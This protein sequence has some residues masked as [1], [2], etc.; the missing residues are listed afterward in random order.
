LTASEA[1]IAGALATGASLKEIA[2]RHEMSYETV[3]L[4]LKHIFAKTGTA[5]AGRS[6]ASAGAGPA[7]GGGTRFHASKGNC[8]ASRLFV[9][10]SAS[11][12]TKTGH[13]ER[14]WPVIVLPSV[15]VRRLR[16]DLPPDEAARLK[17]Y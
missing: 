13:T 6:G 2:G 7:G 3:R 14:V 15:F 17:I 5:S 9:E 8:L 12:Q 16:V 10:M 1:R 4:H 11:P